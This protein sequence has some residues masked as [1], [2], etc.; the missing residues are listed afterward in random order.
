MRPNRRL[1]GAVLLVS[2]GVRILVGQEPK[3]LIRLEP[4]VYPPFAWGSEDEREVEA[5]VKLEPGGR[6]VLIDSGDDDD[7]LD[8]EVRRVARL[9]TYSETCSGRNLPLRFRFELRGEPSVE[10]KASVSFELDNSIVIAANP[11]APLCER[12]ITTEIEAAECYGQGT[13][14]SEAEKYAEAIRCFDRKLSIAP[15]PAAYVERGIANRKSGRLRPAIEDYDQAIRLKPDYAIAF[16][17]RGNVYRDLG[18]A[19]DAIRD[20]SEAI[21]L[22]PNRVEAYG[23]RGIRYLALGI[24]QLALEDFSKVIEMRSRERKAYVNRGLTFGEMGQPERAIEDYDRAILLSR[25]EADAFNNRAAAHFALGRYDRA[26]EDYST[27]IR[28]KPDYLEAWMGRG[29][30]Y[31]S[32]NQYGQAEADFTTA[33]QLRPEF[34][35]AYQTRGLVRLKKADCEG[36][37]V[38]L[39]RAKTLRRGSNE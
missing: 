38:D 31:E 12:K 5:I 15:E 30:T 26:L 19:Q 16:F 1:L 10:R 35:D 2:I 6:P 33:I 23:N 39:E 21:R 13:T 29:L 34:A 28:L 7:D 11:P 25:F 32:L 8:I 4:S 9:S 27:A 17:D 3:C 14:L 22:D 36:A 18:Q 37:S 20:Y 24:F